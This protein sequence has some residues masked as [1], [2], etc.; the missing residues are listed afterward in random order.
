MN[1]LQLNTYINCYSV[2]YFGKPV[3]ENEHYTLFKRIA[4]LI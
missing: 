3:L 4:I 2:F 1:V